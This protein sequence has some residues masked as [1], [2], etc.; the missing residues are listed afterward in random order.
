MAAAPTP[1]A[2]A[3]AAAAALVAA[4][5]ARL[6]REARSLPPES[7]CVAIRGK[8]TVRAKRSIGQLEERRTTGAKGDGD[9]SR[10]RCCRRTCRRRRSSSSS[11]PS[12][13]SRGS[14]ATSTSR[15]SPLLARRRRRPHQ[16]GHVLM[17]QARPRPAPPARRAA[18]PA[19]RPLTPPPPTP[20]QG[21]PAT[22]VAFLFEGGAEGHVG[23]ERVRAVPSGS[24]VGYAPVLPGRR[25]RGRSDRDRGGLPR[26]DNLL[27][28]VQPGGRGERRRKQAAGNALPPDARPYLR[29]RRL[30]RAGRALERTPRCRGRG[31]RRRPTRSRRCSRS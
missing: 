20:L 27:G 17:R 19:P 13:R 7:F 21:E 4:R 11:T 29:R 22:F 31:R 16:R 23:G 15:S 26:R 28:A 3:D 30:R 9:A 1:A 2:A 5:L 10:S 24:A 6:G 12:R 25:A 14:A 8:A 18:R